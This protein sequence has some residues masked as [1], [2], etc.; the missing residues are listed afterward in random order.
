MAI[1]ENDGRVIR[2]KKLIR[3][4]LLELVQEKSIDKISVKELTDRVN[5]N[6][7]TFYLHYKDI[8]SLVESIQNEIFNNFNILLSDVT[9]ERIQSEPI[10]ILFDI[11]SCIKQ[12]S[13]VCTVLFCSDRTSFLARETGNFL[14][15]KFLELFSAAYPNL[16][17]EKYDIIC[18]YFKYGGIG[19]LHSWLTKYPEKSPRQIAELWFSIARGGIVAVLESDGKAVLQQ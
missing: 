18:E 17:D 3:K 1:N 12:N 10:E 16:S 11:C 19:I 2:T 6:R 5:I 8:D 4:S 7:G 14:G 15:R 13:D 9:V